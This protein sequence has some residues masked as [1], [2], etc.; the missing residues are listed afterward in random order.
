MKANQFKLAH[1][2]LLAIKNTYRCNYSF[3]L[4]K[5]YSYAILHVNCA[6]KKN[7][8]KIIQFSE[9]V[10]RLDLQNLFTYYI[11]V[12][13]RFYAYLHIFCKYNHT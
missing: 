9:L 4:E 3:V 2:H 1:I 7:L 8:T 6:F 10:F 13:E 11:Y 5:I 12:K